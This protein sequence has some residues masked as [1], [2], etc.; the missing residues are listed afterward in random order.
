MTTIMKVGHETWHVRADPS[1]R[2]LD[3]HTSRFPFVPD[4][5]HS[6]LVSTRRECSCQLTLYDATSSISQRTASKVE[7]LLSAVVQSV[8]KTTV[9]ALT[10]YSPGNCLEELSKATVDSV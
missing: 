8:L 1:D 10:L 5:P 4:P 6:G 2:F 7:G 3:L 9:Q